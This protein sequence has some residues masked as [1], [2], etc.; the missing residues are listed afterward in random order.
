MSVIRT[1]KLTKYYNRGKVLGIKNLD[2]EVEKGETF[3]FIGPNGAGKTTTIRLFLDLIRP[4]SGDAEIF[5]LDINQ[6]SLKIRKDLGY[7]PGEVFLSEHL[8]GKQCLDFFKSF[9]E[10]VDEK[11]LKDLIK[12]LDFDLKRKVK[13]YSK[14]NKQILAIILVLMHKPKLLL[15]DE[16]TSGLDPLNQQIVYELLNQAKEGETTIFLSTH[17]LTE[18]QK[19]CGR[20][21][22]LKEGK[23]LKIENI[24]ELKN[25]NVRNISIE[26][27]E[28]IPLD[29]LK[30]EG[31]EKVE[32]N[33]DGYHLTTI[34]KIGAL[35]KKINKFDIKDVRISE[36]T[37]EET[38]MHY[39]KK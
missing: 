30:I 22:I 37:L 13:N 1:H 33:K 14:G 8:S 32:K 6:D 21:G 11:Y 31:V 29:S 9:K 12:K 28:R 17:I 34:G 15:L 23:L 5:G 38:F 26:T 39:Y 2:L 16:P 4:T 35:I 24:E 10:K 27:T 7:L 18:A 3:G 25:K 36:P 19:V 20:V